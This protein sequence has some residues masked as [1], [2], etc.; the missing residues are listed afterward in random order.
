MCIISVPSLLP[1]RKEGGNIH[2]LTAAGGW[3]GREV[4]SIPTPSCS[5]R[6]AGT[7]VCKL[8]EE[9]KAAAAGAAGR[10]SLEHPTW[11]CFSENLIICEQ[12]V[13][14]WVSPTKA[15]YP[16]EPRNLPCPPE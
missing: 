1:G 11:D 5:L 2:P 13:P 8:Q 14:D 7:R 16:E 3:G 9:S 15:R 10:R 4:G 6:L 12:N